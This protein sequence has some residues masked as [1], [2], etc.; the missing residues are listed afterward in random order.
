MPTFGVGAG[1]AC[2]LDAGEMEWLAHDGAFRDSSARAASTSS[3]TRNRP[4]ADPGTPSVP[5][6][7]EHGEP[8]GRQ[9]R[10]APAVTF[11]I[12]VEPPPQPL[13]ETLGAID[14]GH[15]NGDDLELSIDG[16][17]GGGL[18]GVFTAH[19]CAAHCD[20]RGVW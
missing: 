16:R 7:M 17:G 2:S 20:L 8:G 1:Q 10:R 11:E 18:G 3:T 5:R 9:L 19:L 14:V 12:G 15:R 13:V 6:C 4:C